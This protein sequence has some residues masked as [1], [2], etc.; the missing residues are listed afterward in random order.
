MTREINNESAKP[1]PL[2]FSSLPVIEVALVLRRLGGVLL[3]GALDGDGPPESVELITPEEAVMFLEA[4][5]GWA[6]WRIRWSHRIPLSRDLLIKPLRRLALDAARRPDTPSGWKRRVLDRVAMDVGGPSLYSFPKSLWRLVG[7]IAWRDLEFQK[8]TAAAIGAHL[9]KRTPLPGGRNPIPRLSPA[10][11]WLLIALAQPA[12]SPFPKRFGA[13]ARKSRNALILIRRET[14]GEILRK[15]WAG[16][17]DQWIIS[18]IL[19]CSPHLFD[20]LPP[21]VLDSLLA[22]PLLEQAEEAP[23]D[24]KK[25]RERKQPS[26]TMGLA[27]P[28]WEQERPG[29]FECMI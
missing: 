2:D 13:G 17:W 24:G 26:A 10:T 11:F 3:D 25:E 5:K 4:R 12:R 22:M 21:D 1:A 14:W 23:P 9:R 16:F 18:S 20:R 28:R 6:D 29:W 27:D 15:G 8:R 19:S 7:E